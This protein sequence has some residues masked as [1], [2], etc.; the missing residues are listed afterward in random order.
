MMAM[1]D[2][3]LT[4]A[5]QQAL[6][7]VALVN[8]ARQVF[9]RDGFHGASLETIAHEAGLSKGAVYSNF[10]SKADLF[11]A[12][13]DDD[14]GQI[15]P[16]TWDPT[17][18]FDPQVRAHGVRSPALSPEYRE[19]LGF[20]WATLEFIASAA[21][22][23]EQAEAMGTRLQRLLGAFEPMATRL[24]RDDDPLE[25]DDLTAMLMAFD[26]GATILWM[27]GWLDIDADTVRRGML[28]LFSPAPN[29]DE[30]RL[31]GGPEG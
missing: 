9:G 21:R 8:S 25:V 6:T 1:A 31:T 23:P 17:D 29:E 2:P 5:E 26:Q 15:D 19:A 4:R 18:R 10:D 7:R 30:D 12:V 11:L 27:I 16:E 3:P 22:D 28:R 13:V 14:L 24:R 20:G